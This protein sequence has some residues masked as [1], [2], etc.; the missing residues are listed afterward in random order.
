MSFLRKTPRAKSEAANSVRVLPAKALLV[1]TTSRNS[2][3][4]SIRALSFTSGPISVPRSMRVSVRVITAMTSPSMNDRCGFR[5]DD[6]ALVADPGDE[7]AV[8]FGMASSLG[9]GLVHQLVIGHPVSPDPKGLI[10]GLHPGFRLFPARNLGLQLL[11]FLFQVDPHQF[12]P[13][14]GNKPNDES[15]ADEVSDRI[16][17]RNVI[18]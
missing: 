16:G 5:F 12:R 1:M 11:S 8:S 4:K 14:I 15:G 10:S 17:H 7:N 18:R 9:D 13:D 6:P 3:G 2:A